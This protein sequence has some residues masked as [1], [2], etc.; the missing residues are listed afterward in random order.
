[1]IPI[2][3][4]ILL[5]LASLSGAMAVAIGAM[6]AHSLP[7]QLE[8]RGLSESEVEKKVHQC[9]LGTRYQMVHALAILVIVLTGHALRS[10]AA[11]IAAIL[12]LLGTVG[13]AGGLYS[14]VFADNII[15]WSIVPLG[16]SLFILGWISLAISS[17]LRNDSSLAVSQHSPS[18]PTSSRNTP[19]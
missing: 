4:R 12:M 16:G 7:K 13:F 2:S 5:L 10:R 11:T 6:G 8:A 17:F 19:Q 3:L 1:M 9:E 15:H 14:I 18:F